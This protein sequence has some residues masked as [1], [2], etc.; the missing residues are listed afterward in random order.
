MESFKVDDE[1]IAEKTYYKNRRILRVKMP[2]GSFINYVTCSGGEQPQSSWILHLQ[3][4]TIQNPYVPKALGGGS[5]I[6]IIVKKSFMNVTVTN[7]N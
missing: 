1:D 2:E 6:P 3:F 5:K 7:N 4:K